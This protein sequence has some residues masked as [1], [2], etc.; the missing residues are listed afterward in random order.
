MLVIADRERPHAIAGVMGGAGSEVSPS[1]RRVVFESACFKPATVRRTSRRLNL[2][3]EASSRFERGADIGAPVK[4]LQRVAA[5]MEEMGAGRIVGPVIDA[6]PDPRQ[7][8]LMLPLRRDRLASLL[9]VKIPDPEVERILR[10]L[11]LM[12]TGTSEGWH[13]VIPTFRVDLVR[14]VDLIEEVGRHYGFDQL[15]ATFPIVTAPAPSPDPRI[16]RDQLVRRVLTGAGFSEAVTFGFI[17]AKAALAFATRESQ[18]AVALANPLS[19][20]FDTLRP[21]LVPGLVDAVAHNRRHGRDDVRLFEIGTRFATAGETRAVGVAWTGA[22]A[23]RHWSCGVRAVDFFDVKGL[24]ELL[25]RTLN[26]LIR[27]EPTAEPFLVLGQSALIVCAGGLARGA[28]VGLVG[29]IS[30]QVA[31]TRG[32]PRQDRVFVRRTGSRSTRARARAEQRHCAS[33]TPLS[34]RRA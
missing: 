5:L 20:K 17:E 16:R 19:A 15:P 28:I 4:A 23:S 33:A 29:Q 8:E 9:G 11:G 13:V 25:S 26:V 34:V 18:P 30:P 12:M 21:L 22:T 1:T 6:Y 32:L 3:T 10:R 27:F 2:K 31:D 24:V 14:E 7:P